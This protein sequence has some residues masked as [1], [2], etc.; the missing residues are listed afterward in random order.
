MNRYCQ[1][2]PA[3]IIAVGIS[4]LTA[5]SLSA[6]AD[7]ADT[8]NIHLTESFARDNNLFRLPD[9]VDPAL[10]GVGDS[11]RSDNIR[12]DSISLTA[13]KQ[14]SLQRFHLGA[15]FDNYAYSTYDY[16]D[17]N[18]KNIDGRWNWSLTPHITGLI[19]A[20]RI[21]TLNSFADYQTYERSIRTTDKVHAD[22]EFGSI[23]ALRFLVGASQN[24]TSDSKQFQQDWGS[25]T[26]SAQAGLRYLSSANSTIGYWYRQNRVDWLGR[27]LNTVALYDTS[28]KQTDHEIFGKLALS[29][30][31]TLEGA[32]IRISRRHDTFAERDYTGTAGRLNFNWAP[33]ASLSFG[34]FAK[35]EYGSWWSS[36]ASYTVTDSYGITPAWRISPKI[37]L[38]GRIEHSEREY[39]GPI[40]ATAGDTRLDK[41]TSSQIGLDWE[42]MR[43]LLLGLYV[44]KVRRSSNQAGLDY[45]DTT[46]SGMIKLTF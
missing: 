38:Y 21:Q 2:F 37:S 32:V 33:E 29:G 12:T 31:T 35:R 30:Q 7:E 28:A 10:L 24:K 16:L 36:T 23:G 11:S 45:D 25:R 5:V 26:R 9:D 40:T 6:R 1:L 43:N 34:A 46:A 22:S 3:P 17:H 15:R 44:R 14:Y 27:D 42:P 39:L 41:T 8:L 18:T 4:F 20:E 13:D 19:S